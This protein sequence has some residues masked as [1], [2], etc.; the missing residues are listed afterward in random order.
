MNEESEEKD[1]WTIVS[2]KKNKH[3]HPSKHQNNCKY[4][5]KQMHTS[6]F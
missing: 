1:E 3:K 2:G 5:D 4:E 6:R